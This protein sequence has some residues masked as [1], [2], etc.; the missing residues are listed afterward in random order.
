MTTDTKKNQAILTVG[1]DDSALGEIKSVLSSCE[2]VEEDN[3]LAALFKLREDKFSSVIVRVPIRSTELD[4]ALRGFRKINVSVRVILLAE[5]FDEPIAMKM[6]QQELADD[7]LILPLRVSELKKILLP[8]TMPSPSIRISNTGDYTLAREMNELI[9][10]A[11]SGLRPLLE[12]ICWSGIFLLKAQSVKIQIEDKLIYAGKETDYYNFSFP[13]SEA[14][15]ETGLLEIRTDETNIPDRR[16]IGFLLELIP[17][18][19]NLDRTQGQLQK[20]ANT[21]ELTGLANRRFMRQVL[22]NLFERA[23]GDPF[24]ITFVIFDFDNFKHYN[25]TYGHNAGDEI[26]RE[27]AMLIR[28]CIRKKDVAARYGGDEFAVILWDSQKK[29]KHQ[30]DHPRSALALM[31]RFRELLRQ[32]TF[33]ML[34]SVGG[35]GL[36]ISGGLAT[37]PWD[38]DNAEDLITRADKALLEAKGSGKDR[39]HLVG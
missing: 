17:G 1:V 23:K 39:I 26:L 33:P 9:N 24:R 20:M 15:K 27:S 5:V 31:H 6:V 8:P 32:H 12:R 18:L 4:G 3:L 37:Y 34:G 21:D 19:V 36:T 38:A 7:Y 28:R 35:S 11:G 14:G 13:I 16:Q 29:R 22:D 10:S 25:D 30:S 2:V